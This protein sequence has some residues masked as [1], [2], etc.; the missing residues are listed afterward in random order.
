MM[1]PPCARSLP[2]PH[3][4]ASARM[5]AKHLSRYEGWQMVVLVCRPRQRWSHRAMLCYRLHPTHSGQR[6]C[7]PQLPSRLPFSPLRSVHLSSSF[8]LSGPA[9]RP[10]LCPHLLPPLYARFLALTSKFDLV[11]AEFLV[12][13]PCIT[14]MSDD[15]RSGR[16]EHVEPPC[17]L[18]ASLDLRRDLG[19][20]DGGWSPLDRD[21]GPSLPGAPAQRGKSPHKFGRNRTD[22][23]V[24][25]EACSVAEELAK[26]DLSEVDIEREIAVER[27]DL[28]TESPEV[29][30]ENRPQDSDEAASDAER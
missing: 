1:Q 25:S 24:Y 13:P 29:P 2:S 14:A 9:P 11:P 12:I 26:S 20:D 15:E 6:D 30:V 7:S 16:S 5:H 17:L 18:A 3:Y 22:T 27:A 23:M 21:R 28:P 19:R 4:H 8:L 10:H